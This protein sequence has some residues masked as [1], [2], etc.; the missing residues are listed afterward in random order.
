MGR[1]KKG[2]PG[3]KNKR[4]V[5]EKGGQKQELLLCCSTRNDGAGTDWEASIISRQAEFLLCSKYSVNLRPVPAG[6]NTSLQLSAK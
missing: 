6:S 2:E 1:K 4:S 3:L 5:P